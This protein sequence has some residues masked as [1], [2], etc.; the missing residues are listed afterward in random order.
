[1]GELYTF[2]GD[3]VD[4]RRPVI[5]A[6]ITTEIGKA[7]IVRENKNDVRFL[8]RSKGPAEK[9]RRTKNKRAASSFDD[10]ATIKNCSCPLGFGP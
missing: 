10:V 7:E 6:P 9:C 8:L 4:M 2:I 3:A 1:V 5:P